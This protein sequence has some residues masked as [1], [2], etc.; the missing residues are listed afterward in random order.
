[1]LFHFFIDFS[2]QIV[3]LSLYRT[4]FHI[5]I[6]KSGRT[7]NLLCP[8]KF[9]ILLILS[10]CCRHKKHL[11][12]PLFKFFKIQRTVIFCRW[13]AESIVH[14]RRF[15]WLVAKIHTSY[16]WHRNVRLINHNQIVIPEVIHQGIRR[17]SRLQSGQMTGIVL[18]TGTKTGLF[19]H[20]QIKVRPFTDSLCLKK[21]V[22][23]F[24]IRHLFFHFL[25]NGLRC[26]QDPLHWNNIMRCR[27]QSNVVQFSSNLPGQY[28]HLRDPI[29]LIPEEFHP[30]RHIRFICR[31]NLHHISP[32]PEG[33]T[34][35]IH[36]ISVILHINQTPQH[37]IPV[38]FHPRTQ[39]DHHILIVL[40]TT[41][42]IDTGNTWYNDDI[43]SFGKG[44]CG[45][46]TEF[47]DFFI[48]GRVLGNV[49]VRGWD[50]GF[51][52]VV[53]V[54]GYKIFHCV[55]REELL[56]FAVKLRSERFIVCYD[57][58]WFI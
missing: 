51:G 34:V 49:S 11:I 35:K 3:N 19:H 16:L 22:F 57:K 37:F 1:M 21:L 20:L 27:V 6:Q 44:C 17:L 50:V 4:H 9:V 42:S 24:K 41:D 31:N 54:V 29:N 18:N 28:I 36:I 43:F 23:T 47:I 12:D 48:D 26:L 38:F 2:Y 8:K 7:D 10:R 25:F 53:I 30:D 56:E 33:S 46:K 39:W 32:H 14:Q 40:R 55:L 58:R 13:K 45:R 5:R 52:L 15:S